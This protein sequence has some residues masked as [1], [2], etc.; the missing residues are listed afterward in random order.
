MAEELVESYKRT[1]SLLQRRA[2]SLRKRSSPKAKQA[3]NDLSTF[4]RLL[5]VTHSLFGEVDELR[6]A[7]AS[8]SEGQGSDSLP[9]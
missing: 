4:I 2:E 5:Q 3:E 8:I 7:L 1:L 6:G 9:N